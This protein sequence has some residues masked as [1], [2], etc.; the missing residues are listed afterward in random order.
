MY[1]GEMKQM[2][3][4]ALRMAALAGAAAVVTGASAPAAKADTLSDALV[5]AYRHSGLL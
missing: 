3:T 5:S 1:F 4:R 2:A